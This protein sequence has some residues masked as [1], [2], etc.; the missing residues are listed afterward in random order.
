M[1]MT[2]KGWGKKPCPSKKRFWLYKENP[3]SWEAVLLT[4]CSTHEYYNLW[5]GQPP[6]TFGSWNMAFLNFELVTFFL[7]HPLQPHPISDI[8]HDWRQVPWNCTLHL[9]LFTYLLLHTC[10]LIEVQ[11]GEFFTTGDIWM[12]PWPWFMISA[13]SQLRYA[14]TVI[15]FHL[16]LDNDFWWHS[17]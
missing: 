14:I 16:F 13:F 11:S 9:L 7:W 12:F 2:H 17:F 5:E 10:W 6:R 1:N 4:V 8:I 15:R 3:L